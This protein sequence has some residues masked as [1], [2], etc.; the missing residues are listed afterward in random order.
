M[1]SQ[2]TPPNHLTDQITAQKQKE[3]GHERYVE[4]CALATTGSLTDSE[5]KLLKAHVL[6]CAVCSDAM[7]EFREIARTAMP[8]L[9]PERSSDEQKSQEEW[10]PAK[11]REELLARVAKGHESGW[12]L[13][14]AGAESIETRETLRYHTR[15]PSARTLLAVAAAL[16]LAAL[17]GSVYRFGWKKGQEALP[18]S[19]FEAGPVQT[20]VRALQQ[21]KE[22]LDASLQAKNLEIETL[23]K[24]AEDA[25]AELASLKSLQ[26]QSESD[27][28]RQASALTETLTQRNVAAAE[29]DALARKLEE[30]ESTAAAL[31]VSLDHLRQERANDLI[32]TASLETQIENLSAHAKQHQE[33]DLSDAQLLASD[34]DIRDLM[35][36]RELYIADVFDV[37]PDSRT[38]KPYGRVFYTHGKSLIFYAFDLDKQRGVRRASTYQAW[39]RRGPHDDRPLNMGIFYLDSDANRRWVLKFD[40]PEELARIESVFVTVE[41]EGGSQEP[42]GKPLL[43]ASLKSQPNHP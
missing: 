39:G 38:E 22:S 31:K 13:A 35:G 8:L 20:Q 41:P 3:S 14:D 6:K 1:N 25:S 12:Q 43:M 5:W 7:L 17:S 10:S 21:E 32:H 15:T 9:I 28:N 18:A 30:A 36:A 24:Q 4:L 16:V 40:N 37:D 29:R 33:S 23:S 2:A 27:L 34:R 42:R 26:K 19:T 11:A